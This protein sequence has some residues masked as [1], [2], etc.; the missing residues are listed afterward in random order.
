MLMSLK[1][2]EPLSCWKLQKTSHHWNH[3]VNMWMDYQNFENLSISYY[4]IAVVQKPSSERGGCLP[5]FPQLDSAPG[6]RTTRETLASV[7]TWSKKRGP[8]VESSG[9]SGGVLLVQ[10][11]YQI[12]HPKNKNWKKNV[13]R[14]PN[15][16]AWSWLWVVGM[17]DYDRYGFDWPIMNANG[18]K[19]HGGW[20][21]LKNKV[22]AGSGFKRKWRIN[23]RLQSVVP[24]TM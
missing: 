20:E 6:R 8:A 16:F 11:R 5:S 24:G 21:G 3:H 19:S 18:C 23:K 1:K 12:S 7:M 15:S 14:K 10:K 9:G 17:K 13:E 4:N 22:Y 2:H